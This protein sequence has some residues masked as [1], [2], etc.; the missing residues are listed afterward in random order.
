MQ[1]KM[2]DHRAQPRGPEAPARLFDHG[3][4]AES[5]GRPDLKEEEPSEGESGGKRGCKGAV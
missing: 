2:N 1:L 5:S 3:D 4:K